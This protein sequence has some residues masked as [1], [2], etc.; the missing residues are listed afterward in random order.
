MRKIIISIFLVL[1]FLCACSGK[2]EEALDWFNKAVA[3]DY[4]DPQKSIEYLNNAIKLQP[5][6][7]TAYFLR[8]NTY[9][10]LNQHQRAIE[11]FNK[12]I[13]LKP[14]DADIYQSRGV[15]Y[16]ML[17][18][19]QPA[20]EDFNKAI[21]LKPDRADVYKC[22]GYVYFSQ[23]NKERGCADAKK[24]CDLG[25]C[26]LSELAKNKRYCH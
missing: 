24:A 18:R 22:R 2:N 11:D 20:I 5:K 6:F 4:T 17:L 21:S 7:G 25:N 1:I 8:G 26:V 13:L 14:K 3:L 10:K 15:E 12:A 23:G 19:Y 9:A 16:T